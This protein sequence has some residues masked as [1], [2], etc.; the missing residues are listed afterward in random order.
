MQAISR[1][2]AI[3]KKDVRALSEATEGFYPGPFN[4]IFHPTASKAYANIVKEALLFKIKYL[5]SFRYV[6][7]D[8]KFLQSH[9]LLFMFSTQS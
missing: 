7:L 1:R 5:D 2:L 4:F 3:K 6:K 9:I 8:V